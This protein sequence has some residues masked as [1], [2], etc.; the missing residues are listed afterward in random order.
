MPSRNDTAHAHDEI[1]IDRE[2]GRRVAELRIARGMSQSDLGRCIDLTFQQVQKYE[3]GANRISVSRLFTIATA[4]GVPAADLLPETAS[5]TIS[6]A[7]ALPLN[8]TL[9]RAMLKMSEQDLDLLTD[10]AVML[11]RRSR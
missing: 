8:A 3:K 2:V 6:E 9:T 7:A 1:A 5:F 10:F 11:S 4:L